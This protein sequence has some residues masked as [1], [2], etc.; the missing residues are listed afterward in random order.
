[1]LRPVLPLAILTLGV[2]GSLIHAA[3]PAAPRQFHTIE[4]IE[5]SYRADQ[6]PHRMQLVHEGMQAS[7]DESEAP[8]IMDVLAAAS[9]SSPGEAVSFSLAREA[10]ALA[11]IGK[12]TADGDAEGLCR[13]DPNDDYV[14]GLTE[15]G[16]APED[17]NTVLALALVDGR[18]ASVDA[19]SR[20]GFRI[21]SA[22]D[23]IA[24]AALHVTG[25]YAAELRG[26]G[27]VIDNVDDLV[28]ARAVGLDA[29]WLTA[30]AKAGYPNLTVNRAIAMR[31]L[32]VTP[33]YARRMKQV[34]AALGE[35]M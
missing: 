26:A 5:W 31:A 7:L 10:G 28:T 27:L 33:D 20:A 35:P 25:E 24:V 14:T 15:R 22:E 12:T 1:M 32:D 13:F 3:T 9:P 34:V 29:E 21:E 2:T 30:M 17:D 19:L 16:L 6:E 11:C 8:E 18:L 4:G 23:L